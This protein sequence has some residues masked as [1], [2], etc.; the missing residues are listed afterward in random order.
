ML[1]FVLRAAY[2]GVRDTPNVMLAA[3][4]TSAYSLLERMI[5]AATSALGARC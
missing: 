2:A 5:E 4:D 1:C 3:D